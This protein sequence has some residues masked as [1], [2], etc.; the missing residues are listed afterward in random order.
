[1][2]IYLKLPGDG[3]FTFEKEKKDD[4]VFSAI[5]VFFAAALIALLPF[6]PFLLL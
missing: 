4:G 6:I 5:A 3:E 2:K 1:M